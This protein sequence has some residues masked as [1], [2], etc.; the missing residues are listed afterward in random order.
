MQMKFQH[1]MLTVWENCEL[2]LF[3]VFETC[4]TVCWYILFVTVC[5]QSGD[6]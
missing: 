3:I 6:G 4:G 2:L 5:E 1:L